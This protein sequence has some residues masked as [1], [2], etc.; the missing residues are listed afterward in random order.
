MIGRAQ[1]ERKSSVQSLAVYLCTNVTPCVPKTGFIFVS[2]GL[3]P[4]YSLAFTTILTTAPIRNSTCLEKRSCIRQGDSSAKLDVK[5]GSNA[6]D[7]SPLLAPSWAVDGPVE[8]WYTPQNGDNAVYAHAT[9]TASAKV[10]TSASP[11]LTVGGS[12]CI[13]IVSSSLSQST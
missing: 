4:E 1:R 3:G 8:W 10:P 13:S 6:T 5:P 12:N 11:A 7:V 9:V 2:G